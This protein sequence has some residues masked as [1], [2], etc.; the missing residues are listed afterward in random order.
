MVLWLLSLAAAAP[1]YLSAGGPF[2]D[3]T[4]WM[5]ELAHHAPL[6]GVA[7]FPGRVGFERFRVLADREG[8]PV[9]RDP[10][11][12]STILHIW[13]PFLPVPPPGPDTGDTAT[14]DTGTPEPTPDFRPD[15]AWLDPDF[16]IAAAEALRFPGGEATGLTVADIEYGWTV[17]HEDLEAAV[18]AFAWGWNSEQYGYHGTSVL[19]QLRATWNGFGVDGA[20]AGA[21]VMVISPFSDPE[22]YDVAA[23]ILAGVDLLG[24]GDVLLIEQQAYVGGDYC[25]VEVDPAVFAAIEAAVA[26]GIVVVEPGGNGAQDL[27]D[28]EWGGVFDRA[29]QDSGA[30]LVGGGSSP[31]S[32]W[33]TRGW[34]SNGSSYGTRVDVQGWYDSIVTST[35]GDYDGYLAD[36]YYPDD[37]PLRAYTDSFG[38]TS[39]ASPM[40]S[41]VAVIAQGVR[42]ARTG[43]PWH[44]LDLRASLVS[45]GLAQ[46]VEDAH[47]IGPQPT[48]RSLLR[49]YG[50]P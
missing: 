7:R 28:A 48:L 13:R 29:Q 39:G 1:A 22:T 38:G 49:T 31:L 30:V 16:G 20:V 40:V 50:R 46:P 42:I 25:P 19:G 2:R 15:Q 41:A 32:R 5:V 4:R 37:D 11:K 3:E 6:V 10:A 17:A 8:L 36:L 27:D 44:P 35:N 21:A 45:T 9:A 23:A 43:A 24:P 12:Y 47:R 26:D 14:E 34:P 18:N 33:E